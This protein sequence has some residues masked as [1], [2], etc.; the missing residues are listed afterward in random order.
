[1]VGTLPNNAVVKGAR[2][3]PGFAVALAM[4]GAV[5]VLPARCDAFL[6]DSFSEPAEALV[7]DG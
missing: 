4:T 2:P 7:S 6:N 3:K 1:L 5:T